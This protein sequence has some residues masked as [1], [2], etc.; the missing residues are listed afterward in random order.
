MAGP[1]PARLEVDG[2]TRGALAE[3]ARAHGTGQQ[4][5]LRAR[6][7]L[8]AAEG[9]NNTQ[10]ARACGI[11]AKTARLW[12]ARWGSWGEVPLA[13]VGVVERLTDAPRPDAPAHIG[14]EQ[15]CQIM[16]VA[17]EQPAESERPISHWSPRELADE[18]MRRGIVA[19]I[20][21]RHA[22]RLLKR[23]RPSATPEPLLAHPVPDRA[24]RAARGADR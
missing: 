23:G 7:V 10:V 3:V 22:G 18:I 8:A 9:L 20:S 12:R 16:A 24:R 5:A 1:T 6:I 15:V 4:V 14:P 21:P 13:E 17:C 11:A 19:H 2:V